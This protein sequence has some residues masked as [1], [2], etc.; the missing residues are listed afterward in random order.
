VLYHH[1]ISVNLVHLV[2]V[3]LSD[4][5]ILEVP[6]LF[7]ILLVKFLIGILDSLNLEEE[8]LD[9][10]IEKLLCSDTLYREVKFVEY[11]RGRQGQFGGI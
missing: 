9:E 10:V 4:I 3:L 7:L 8:G 2:I 1:V 11:I 6:E 5:A